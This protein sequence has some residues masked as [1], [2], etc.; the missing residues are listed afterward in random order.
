MKFENEILV[1]ALYDLLCRGTQDKCY[2][3]AAC[4]YAHCCWDVGVFNLDQYLYVFE[5]S[6]LQKIDM[7]F[8]KFLEKIKEIK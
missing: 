6:K 4:G 5:Y 1:G 8:T 2:S 3:D 7:S